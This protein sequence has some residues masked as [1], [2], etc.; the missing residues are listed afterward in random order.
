MSV[1]IVGK[2]TGDTAKF[3]QALADRASEFAEI[4]E[5]ARS[6]GGIHHRFG[7]G[8][9]FI[10]VIDEW[11]SADHFMKFFSDPNLQAF[12]GS[13]GADPGP[14]EMIVAEALSSPDQY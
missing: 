3:G 7:V 12:I 5:R 2:F 10:V 9:G 13:V 8:D 14:P 1:L 6:E 11:E 4:G